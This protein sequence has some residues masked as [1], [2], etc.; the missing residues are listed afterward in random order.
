MLSKAEKFVLGFSGK[1][2]ESAASATFY[3]NLAIHQEP[4]KKKLIAR[5]A[6]VFFI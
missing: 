2:M 6:S 5:R 4:L 1:G 3:F